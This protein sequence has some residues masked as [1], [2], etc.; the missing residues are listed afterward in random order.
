MH[1]VYLNKPVFDSGAD[2]QFVQ[3]LLALKM[4]PLDWFVEAMLKEGAMAVNFLP[5]TSRFCRPGD[6]DV[7]KARSYLVRAVRLAFEVLDRIQKGLLPGVLDSDKAESC[8]RA[9]LRQY[10]FYL[11][12]AFH[13]PWALPGKQKAARP[14][15]AK[16]LYEVLSHM[17]DFDANRYISYMYSKGHF[18]DKS[19]Y[20]SRRSAA[21]WMRKAHG[22]DPSSS[23]AN[24]GESWAWKRKYV[25]VYKRPQKSCCAWCRDCRSKHRHKL[26]FWQKLHPV[27]LTS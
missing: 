3:G 6:D 7:I 13:C 12:Q 9:D 4:L 22:D 25:E 15:V 8:I 18:G 21:F 14:A 26:F 20:E 24:F 11:A 19:S 17:G 23:R 27:T 1:A 5:D 10:I 16:F 2:E